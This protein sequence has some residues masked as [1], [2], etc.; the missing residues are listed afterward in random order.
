MATQYRLG[1]GSLGQDSLGQSR[2]VED[3]ADT[4]GAGA[5]LP[6]P[7]SREN[8]EE[9]IR[10]RGLR[11]DGERFFQ[12]YSERHWL[13]SNGKPLRQWGKRL[14]RWNEDERNAKIADE[15]KSAE[16]IAA[17]QEQR[18][19]EMTRLIER[20][21]GGEDKHETQRQPV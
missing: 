14:E 4:G 20:L 18:E 19:R 21:N 17:E 7:P 2:L 1:E 5:P 15:V 13:Q 8:V 6:Y 10:A 11:V 9:Y 3:R 16:Q 12:Y